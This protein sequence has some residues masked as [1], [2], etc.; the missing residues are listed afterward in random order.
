MKKLL[1]LFFPFLLF[2]QTTPP[3][4]LWERI[5]ENNYTPNRGNVFSSILKASSNE[6]ILIANINE[7][8]FP[9]D[10]YNSILKINSNGD[11]IWLQNY[12][13][14][15][16][17]N[18]LIQTIAKCTDNLYYVLAKN[19]EDNQ[20]TSI[21]QLDDEGN[22]LAN[23]CYPIQGGSGFN[24]I[25]DTNDG[26]LLIS[27]QNIVT[28]L[29]AQKEIQWSTGVHYENIFTSLLETSDGHF[30]AVGVG[31]ANR[32][33]LEESQTG[34][35]YYVKIDSNGNILWEKN[36]GAPNAT[37]EGVSTVKEMTNGN[38][39]L[40]CYTDGD[41]QNGN[42]GN[43]TNAW[44]VTTDSS[45]NII[46]SFTLTS[47]GTPAA[48]SFSKIILEPDG[49]YVVGTWISHCSTPSGPPIYAFRLIKVNSNNTIA[50]DV[51]FTDG[52]I[53]DIERTAEGDYIA[54]GTDYNPSVFGSGS[55]KAMKIGWEPLS[56]PSF[57]NSV[58]IYPNP[59][60]D[61]IM[62][63]NNFT[64]NQAVVIYN[65]AGQTIIKQEINQNENS[66]DVSQLANGIYFVHLP[67]SNTTL[68]WI[69][70]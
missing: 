70:G 37:L 26:G 23:W 6:Y 59:A 39:L 41:L 58:S 17:Q 4:I 5:Y 7:T 45:G 65:V 21:Q 38:F 2:S 32:D 19:C 27:S 10:E 13:I 69:K 1:L 57:E 61:F 22:L 28:K 55:L 30:L 68:K 8:N 35:C 53:Y 40:N 67:E 60:Q 16:Y 63:K 25:I 56:T 66:L 14:F 9:D 54:V 46:N 11:L 24:S 42:I 48:M 3:T 47:N 49:G 62:V 20:Q 33:E 50:W 51:S 31:Y 43:C 29:N 64:E 52:I 15:F 12:N 34:L 44:M 18:S 36:F